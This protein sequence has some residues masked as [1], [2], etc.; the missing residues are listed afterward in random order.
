[1]TSRVEGEE[2]GKREEEGRKV[3]GRG[4]EGGPLDG[5]GRCWLVREEHEKKVSWLEEELKRWGD[6]PRHH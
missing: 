6:G 1:V 4:G 5:C 3:D 2:R